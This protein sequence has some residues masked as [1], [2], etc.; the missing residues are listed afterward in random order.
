MFWIILWVF[1]SFMNSFWMVMTKKVVENKAVWNN[2]QIFIS[3]WNHAIFLI[4][5]FFIT[6]TFF[7]IKSLNFNFPDNILSFKN[8]ILFLLSTFWI[9][10]TYYLRRTA[11][12]NEKVSV[13]QPFAMLFQVFPVIL[14]FVFIASERANLITFLVAIV[15]SF[16]VIIPNI[17][18]KQFKMNKYSLMV[19][20]SS[21][22]KSWQIFIVL[23]FL[24]LF[25]PI[26]FYFVESILIILISI[27]MIL[28][29][30]E[31]SE[32]KKITKKYTKLLFSANLIAV[33]SV[34]LVLTMYSTLWVVI[35]SLLSLLYLVFVYMFWYIILK[36]I[37][38]KKDVII[39]ILVS[40]CII[41]WMLFKN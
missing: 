38:T 10:F 27:F 33:I 15:A 36:E 4:V 28:L 11:Y 29:K 26:S 39:A 8:I 12:A 21:T 18:W 25:S 3:R 22:I 17:E 1:Q 35:T 14:G 40:L 20:L 24:T 41:I 2:W 6:S 34:L 9:Y 23:Y 16:I 37:P 5:I 32:I 31:F 19:L 13:L 30:W 7:D